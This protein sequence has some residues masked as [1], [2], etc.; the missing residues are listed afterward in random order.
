MHRLNQM[1]A[2]LQGKMLVK[3]IQPEFVNPISA[4]EFS[5]ITSNPAGDC[6]KASLSLIFTV[7]SLFTGTSRL[8]D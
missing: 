8:I 7:L 3:S 5:Q 4:I 1:N 2:I 6:P